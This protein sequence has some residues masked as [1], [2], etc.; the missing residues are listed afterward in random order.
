MKYLLI[1]LVAALLFMPFPGAVHLFNQDEMDLAA[2]AR[3]IIVSR[4]YSQVLVGSH[5]FPPLFVWMQVGSMLLFGAGDFAARFPNA[6]MGVIT[7]VFL[8]GAGKKLVDERMGFWWALVYAGTWLPHLFF[9][10]G[11][12]DPVFNFFVFLSIYF[13]F[14]TGYN[15]KTL[16]MAIFSGLS[17][18]MAVLTN[19]PIAIIPVLL[20]LL[21]YWIWNKGKLSVRLPHLGLIILFSLLP[22]LLWLGYEAATG[23][24]SFAKAFVT[25]QLQQPAGAG[26]GFNGPFYYY[27]VLLLIGCFPAS[28][29][30]FTYLQGKK[31]TIYARPAAIETK[32][33]K[34]WMWVFFWVA[35]LLLSVVPVRTAHYLSLC[36]L[37][38]SFLAAWQ[39]YRFSEGKQ[40]LYGW[41]IAILLCFGLALG[42]VITLLPLTGVYSEMLSP[43]IDPQYAL[44][45]LKTGVPWSVAEAAYG[46]GY[47]IVVIISGV[48]LMRGQV[49]KGLLCLFIGSVVMIAIVVVR[50]APKIAARSIGFHAKAQGDWTG[51]DFK[52]AEGSRKGALRLCVKLFA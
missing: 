52:P 15:K 26:S 27:W 1:A 37:P 17:L 19:G 36:Y 3:E 13:A 11:V 40:R 10:S 42:L 33:F 41:S 49:S 50:F 32:D 38:L 39:V 30:L 7:L 28:A 34:V 51:A 45:G 21:V 8:F 35:L 20:C 18:G 22:L 25:D 2:A 9:K 46:A 16:R 48:L 43:Y 24:G 23:G 14:R 5:P 29:F 44:A 6:V 47:M 12:T 31:K 4:H